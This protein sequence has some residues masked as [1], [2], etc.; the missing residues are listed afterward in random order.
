LLLGLAIAGIGVYLLASKQGISMPA[1]LIGVGL[2]FT[3]FRVVSILGA[4]T[5]IGAGAYWLYFNG[6]AGILQGGLFIVC[7]GFFLVE[8]LRPR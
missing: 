3:P 2:A 4:L 1:F 8:R 5:C 7:G 6:Q